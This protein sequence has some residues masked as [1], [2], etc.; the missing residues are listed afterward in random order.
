MRRP[1]IAAVGAVALA[2]A[3]VA[4]TR[5]MANPAAADHNLAGNNTAGR[6]AA[7]HKAPGHGQ[8]YAALSGSRYQATAAG[9]RA[10]LFNTQNFTG[11]PITRIAGVD[12]RAGT[13][14]PLPGIAPDTFSIRWT[15]TLKI[16]KTGVHTFHSRSDDGF[17]LWVNNKAVIANWTLHPATDNTGTIHLKAG[18]KATVKV[19]YFERYGEAVA[20]LDLTEPGAKRAALPRHRL[21]PPAP[22]T[23][24]TTPRPT[25]RPPTTSPRPTMTPT[26][27]PT[28]PPPTTPRPTTPAPTRPTATPTTSPRPTTPPS[29]P[30]PTTPDSGTNAQERAV[31]DLTNAER[32]K[33]GCAPLALDSSL[34]KAAGD[35]ASDMVR[36]HYFSH[37]SLD[38]RS[39]FD[40]MK[41]AGFRGGM[42]GENIAAGQGSPQSAMTAWMNSSGH[43]ANILNCSYNKIGIG[44]DPGEVKP[45]MRGSWVQNFGR[46]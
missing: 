18:T 45:N 9:L 43:R 10:D 37:D 8:S 31:L 40:R 5:L 3:L 29:T 22:A 17:R 20:R 41:A 16:T 14:A 21:A 7:D 4:G 28:T 34:V 25:S 36:Q 33:A 15:G 39:P 19:E 26:V 38:G 6:T 13:R 32:Q 30:P 35:H 2:G 12:L 27:R 11:K 46:S 24:P 1:L 23:P 42:M 44:Y